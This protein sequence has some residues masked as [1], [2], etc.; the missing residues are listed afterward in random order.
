MSD[1]NFVYLTFRG[2]YQ[3]ADARQVTRYLDRVLADVH[4]PTIRVSDGSELTSEQFQLT[5]DGIH[6]LASWADQARAK[7]PDSTVYLVGTTDFIYGMSRMYS[8]LASDR[9]TPV[10]VVR[11]RDE[12]PE[13][14]RL[15]MSAR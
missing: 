15:R 8:S 3:D 14:I 13:E 4:G 11:S 12:L 10:I 9:R 6:T 7:W 2:V 1:G 5:P